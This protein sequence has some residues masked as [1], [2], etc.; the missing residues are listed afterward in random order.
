MHVVLPFNYHHFYYFYVIA[1]EGGISRAAKKLLISQP[2]LSSQLKHLEENLGIELFQREGKA[3]ILS[4]KG[5]TALSYAKTIFTTGH[6]LS[7]ILRNDN[8]SGKAPLRIGISKFTA[9]ACTSELIR[10]FYRNAPNAY[11]IQQEDKLENLVHELKAHA[12][13]LIFTDTA[14]KRRLS[15]G[16]ENHLVGKIPIVFCA[17]TKY[18]N[19]VKH[20][21]ADIDGLPFAMPASPS[22]IFESVTQYLTKHHIKP[23]VSG[24]FEDAELVLKL[25]LKGEAVGALN[26]FTV[27]DSAG[28]PQLHILKSPLKLFDYLYIITKKRKK[29]HPLVEIAL[30]NFRLKI[31]RISG[32]ACK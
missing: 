25:I 11:I 28:C 15:D 31:P 9:K 20:F 21:P 3:M 23:N 5:R 14:F 7:D 29:P 2:A 13:D 4:A 1:Q 12:I 17:N 10:F 32:A 18:K 22:Q 6:E 27:H 30:K 24:E 26:Q 19:K 16:V 8:T